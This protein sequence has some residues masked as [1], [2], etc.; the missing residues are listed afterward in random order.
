MNIEDIGGQQFDQDVNDG[1]LKIRI[2]DNNESENDVVNNPSHY[3]S[4]D[5]EVIDYIKDKL[6][7]E[8][9]EGFCMGN[10]IKYVSRYR[11]KNGV[12]DLRK[13]S[14]YLERVTEIEESK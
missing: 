14:W 6:T 11:H 10:V 13:A 12:E 7:P 9:F 4:G 5:I 8:Q 1:K 2:E 3:T